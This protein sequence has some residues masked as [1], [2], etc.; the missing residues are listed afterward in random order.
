MGRQ[1]GAGL[2][3]RPR[4]IVQHP[5]RKAGV[6][7]ALRDHADRERR[8]VRRLDDERTAGRERGTEFPGIDIDRDSSRA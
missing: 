4:H 6:G 1:R 7:E 2:R 3:S 8:L 5:G